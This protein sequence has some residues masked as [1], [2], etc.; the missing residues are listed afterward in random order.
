MTL[1]NETGVPVYYWISSP[2]SADCGDIA[3]DGIA[4]WPA[5]DN[6][7]N[8]TISFLPL[9]GQPNFEVV[10]GTTQTGE[11]VQMALVAE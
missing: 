2:N 3:V 5:Y 7:Q 6:Q 11:Q 8:V 1:V 4:D 10:C 9:N